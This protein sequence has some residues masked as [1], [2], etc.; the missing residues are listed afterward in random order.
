M[1]LNKI[2]LQAFRGFPKKATISFS[3]SVTI[4]AAPNGSGKTS[5]SEAFEWGMF[6]EIA[7]KDRSRTSGEF[8]RGF[9]FLR[10]VHAEP[11]DMTFVEIEIEHS[12]KTYSIR[13]EINGVD[14]KLYL[15]GAEVDS[16]E[17]IG[18][19]TTTST[20]PCL[21]QSEIKAFIDTPPIERWEQISAILGLHEFG[22]IRSRL[23]LSR[24]DIDKDERVKRLRNTVMSVVGPFTKDGENPLEVSVDDL[25]V[26]L[27]KKLGLDEGSSWN[28]ARVRALAK[29]KHLVNKDKKPKGFEKLEN[30][31]DE[32]ITELL[33]NLLENTL[34]DLPEHRRIHKSNEAARFISSGVKLAKPPKCPFCGEDTLSEAK[35]SLITKKTQSSENK[36]ES[37]NSRD[38][39]LREFNSLKSSL[40]IKIPEG[41]VASLG[42]ALPDDFSE[43]Q[44]LNTL[45]D[46]QKNLADKAIDADVELSGI[47]N[48]LQPADETPINEIESIVD[49]FT[50]RLEKL[51]TKYQEFWSDCKTVKQA[52]ELVLSG[53]SEQERSALSYL[54]AIV[55]VCEKSDTLYK[56]EK[57]NQLSSDM[58]ELVVKL[59]SK[60]KSLV[61]ESLTDLADDV[62]KYYSQINKDSTLEFKGFQVKEGSRRQA[63]LEASSYGVPVNPTSMFSEA[64]SNSLGLSLYFSQRIDR[65]PLWETIILDDPVQSMDEAHKE[66]L[67]SLLGT[68][69]ESKQ[70]IVF[71]HDKS[72]RESLE[73]EFSKH[74]DMIK[75]T[76]FRNDSS[77]V[78]TVNMDKAKFERM[79]EH[80]KS[81]SRGD[82]IQ[83]ENACNTM[84][85]SVERFITDFS[86]VRGLNP[87]KSGSIEDKI[88]SLSTTA[89]KKAK[90]HRARSY[91]TRGSHDSSSPITGSGI[92]TIL[93][94]L[95]TLYK[96]LVVDYV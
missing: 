1:K 42:D 40:S 55:N 77:P 87:P 88:N 28:D 17:S 43:M 26:V 74:D 36:E 51:A 2:T 22:A 70:I 7:R 15:D 38:A 52:A 54:Q 58:S 39:I 81:L 59:E 84:R 67:I 90:L 19:V 60:E 56:N 45:L 12:S 92:R 5:I 79:I 50:V 32:L 65:N 95:N 27:V 68:L 85:S 91:G 73:H 61:A 37:D 18:V 75:F 69:S 16:L 72:F 96:E 62:V 21:G 9:S 10:S 46:K 4:F 57:L 47:L 89:D 48:K 30:E 13:R 94:E 33:T 24:N 78:P 25:L 86:H 53:L 44:K 6:G 11:N 20:K 14:T 80:A 23:Q 31:Q 93:G 66:D 3:K 71:T 83:L 63:S 29:I 8:G 82:E 49:K 41:L 64:Q 76:I 35:L 34:K